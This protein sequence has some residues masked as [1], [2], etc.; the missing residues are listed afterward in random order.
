[1]IFMQ[2]VCHVAKYVD[3]F[4]MSEPN[5]KNVSIREV[6]TTQV[7]HLPRQALLMY[8]ELGTPR[9]ALI[10]MLNC[11]VRALATSEC[12]FSTKMIFDPV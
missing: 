9:Q 1:M 2:E 5:S 6:G 7:G 10:M 11:S 12:T 4:L 8:L 3:L